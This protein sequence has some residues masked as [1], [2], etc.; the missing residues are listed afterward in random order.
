M[1]NRDLSDVSHDELSRGMVK[2]VA[3]VRALALEAVLVFYDEASSRRPD[4]TRI[5]GSERC[6][7]RERSTRR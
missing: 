3:I 1:M 2:R 7:M 4:W 5:T 6:R